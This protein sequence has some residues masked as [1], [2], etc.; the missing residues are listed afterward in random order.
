MPVLFNQSVVEVQS[1]LNHSG[2]RQFGRFFITGAMG[3]TIDACLLLLLNEAGLGPYWSRAISFPTALAATWLANRYWTFAQ[4]RSDNHVQEFSMY[5]AVVMSGATINLAIY[6]LLLM[7]YEP[8]HNWL[9][10]PLA[11]GAAAG[12]AVNYSGSALLVFN[13]EKENTTPISKP[14]AVRSKQTE[15]MKHD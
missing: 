12:L 1:L 9:I 4:K 13:S 10:V 14:E 15:F 3:F 5:A 8:L 2:V 7:T 11:L 6:A